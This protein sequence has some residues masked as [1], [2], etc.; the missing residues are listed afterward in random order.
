MLR[1]SLSVGTVCLLSF[2]AATTD[3][4]LASAQ[5]TEPHGWAVN[6]TLDTRFGD[7]KFEG[8]YPARDAT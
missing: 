2:L 3:A 6:E 4:Q 1:T 5:Q 7:F 8:G